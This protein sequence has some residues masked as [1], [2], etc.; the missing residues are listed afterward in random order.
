MWDVVDTIRS[1][2][3]DWEPPTGGGRRVAFAVQVDTP[4]EVD[5]LY[6]E[7][8]SAGG[9]AGVAPWDAVWGQRYAVLDDPDGNEIDLYAPSQP[10]D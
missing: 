3:P 4:D 10:P 8:T 6:A 2:R 9:T 7:L 5:A 1:F